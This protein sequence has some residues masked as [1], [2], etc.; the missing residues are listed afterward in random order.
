MLRIAEN[1][2][3]DN[4]GNSGNNDD[5]NNAKIY[6]I[7]MKLIK[8]EKE[9]YLTSTFSSTNSNLLKRFKFGVSNEYCHV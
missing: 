3:G 9:I 7:T 6:L 2:V 1:D 8:K 4:N 5:D